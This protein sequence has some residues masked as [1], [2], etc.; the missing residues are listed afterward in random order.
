LAETAPI[1]QVLSYLAARQLVVKELY[2]ARITA[3]GI[4]KIEAALERPSEPAAPY[5]PPINMISAHTINMAP[6]SQLMQGRDHLLQ[7]S[8]ATMGIPELRQALDAIKNLALEL[9]ETDRRQIEG[10]IALVR[11]E[12]DRP[13]P[14]H[15]AIR[16][17][18]VSM[19][20]VA[21]IFAGG[22]AANLATAPAIVEQVQHLLSHWTGG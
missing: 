20:T 14:N 2:T 6:G 4:E 7:S 1:E 10:L 18:L 11:T 19:K 13:T 8:Q 21:E 16:T 9:A 5:L 22:A 17:L 12:A 15:R 3:L